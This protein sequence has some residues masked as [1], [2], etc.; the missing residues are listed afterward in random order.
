MSLTTTEKRA[1]KYCS[2]GQEVPLLDSVPQKVN[3]NHQIPTTEYNH[4]VLENASLLHA[5]AV[6]QRVAIAQVLIDLGID[7]NL[8]DAKD[9]FSC[10]AFHFPSSD[11][12]LHLLRLRQR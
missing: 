2:A 1:F 10:M 6:H 7:L 11:P 5:A 9:S 3:I 4:I 12:R 8:R